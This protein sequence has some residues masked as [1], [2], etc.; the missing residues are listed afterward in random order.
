M[1]AQQTPATHQLL[2]WLREREANARAIAKSKT[3]EDRDGW[4]EDAIYFQTAA[5]CVWQ[6][7][8]TLAALKDILRIATSASIG[9]TGNQP[10]LERAR[11]AIAKAA[12]SPK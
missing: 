12:G 4:L 3:G 11:A 1:D 8:E 6:S 2:D 5:D 9:M 7:A 10:R